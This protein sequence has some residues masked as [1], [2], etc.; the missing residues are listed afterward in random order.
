V[1]WEKRRGNEEGGRK[2]WEGRGRMRER[3]EGDRRSE[4]L[5]GKF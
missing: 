5:K 2:G 3:K 4:S 1:G